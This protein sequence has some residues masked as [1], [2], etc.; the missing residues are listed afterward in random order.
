MSLSWFV[1]L[2]HSVENAGI[3]ESL[4]VLVFLDCQECRLQFCG[5][6]LPRDGFDGYEVFFAIID[7]CYLDD[8]DRHS[9]CCLVTIAVRIFYCL[10][11]RPVGACDFDCLHFCGQFERPSGQSESDRPNH[12]GKWIVIL[13]ILAF[14]VVHEDKIFV[15]NDRCEWKSSVSTS[16]EN[17]RIAVLIKLDVLRI[18]GCK[19]PRCEYRHLCQYLRFEIFCLYSKYPK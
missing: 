7:V 16:T 3:E 2:H 17:I 1:I 14:A 13:K 18:D 8:K 6:P 9:H 12:I 19:Q 11:V 10:I 4:L 15:Y 5:R